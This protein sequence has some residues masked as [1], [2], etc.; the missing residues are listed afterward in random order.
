VTL[1]LILIGLVITLEPI[2]LIAFLIVLGSRRG[3]RNGAA[4]IF[5]WLVSMAIV[6]ALTI[7]VT[8]NHPPAPSTAPSLAAL[9][10]KMAI[11][12]GLLLVAARQRRVMHRPKKSKPEPKWH[13]KVDSM[14]P[15]FAL[16]LA[17]LV[18]PWG[19]IGAAAATIVEAHVS[20]AA[21]SLTFVAFAIVATGAYI[22]MECYVGFRPDQGKALLQSMRNWVEGHTDQVIIVASLALGLWLIAKSTYALMN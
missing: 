15:W 20:G 22:V 1:D 19:L 21:S 17:A 5:G 8:M 14:S 16:G 3:V 18:Q 13:A 7:T 4:F 11:G 12:V 2:P 10:A 9:A 6:I